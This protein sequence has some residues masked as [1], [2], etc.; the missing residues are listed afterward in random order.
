MKQTVKTHR[1]IHL[2]NLLR[3]A[4]PD[5]IYVENGTNTSITRRALIQEIKE[6]IE[7]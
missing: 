2:E 3:E 1:E 7:K 6:V 4:L 5:L